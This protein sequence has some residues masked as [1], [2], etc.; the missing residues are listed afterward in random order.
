MVL[1]DDTNHE[2]VKEFHK[3]FDIPIKPIG[4]LPTDGRALLRIR[5]IQE[6]LAE[7]TEA[8]QLGQ[9]VNLAKE[10]GDLLYVIYGA[11][12][13]FGVPI[14]DVFR[15][16]HKSNMTKSHEP[17]P[18]GKIVKGK[19]YEPADTEKVLTNAAIQGDK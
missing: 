4:H 10:L 13:E 3:K 5:L 6:E 2:L 12:A 9:Y 8:I 1:R 14:D 15:E 16:V 18:G 7:L 17:D 11:A 19:D